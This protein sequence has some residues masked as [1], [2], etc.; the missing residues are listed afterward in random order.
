MLS[1]S[2]PSG[3]I[4]LIAQVLTGRDIAFAKMLAQKLVAEPRTVAVVGCGAGQPALVFAQWRGGPF[5]MGG[6]MKQEMARLGSRGGGSRELAQG[7]V[8]ELEQLDSAI[9]RAK[10]AILLQSSSAAAAPASRPR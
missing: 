10:A 6:L 2:E 8:P 4:K 5:D 3:D 9:E 7:G 1:A